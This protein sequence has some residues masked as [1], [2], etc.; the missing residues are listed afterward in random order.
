M[1]SNLSFKLSDSCC[2]ELTI[3]SPLSTWAGAGHEP[4]KLQSYKAWTNHLFWAL[5]ENRDLT[6]FKSLFTQIIRSSHL[7]PTPNQFVAFILQNSGGAE[8]FISLDFTFCM[9]TWQ[10][11]FLALSQKKKKKRKEKEK[12]FS[13]SWE[14][15]SDHGPIEIPEIVYRSHCAPLTRWNH[16]P[17]CW[18]FQ[19]YP[20]FSSF[21]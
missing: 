7:S 1:T 3:Q 8:A 5:L 19:F 21:L 17:L 9:E 14:E 2:K 12:I 20:R 4:S 10:L 15:T 11:R 16:L 6:I 13:L 18:D